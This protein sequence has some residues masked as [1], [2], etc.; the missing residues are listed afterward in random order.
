MLSRQVEILIGN[1]HRQHCLIYTITICHLDTWVEFLWQSWRGK[2][3][4]LQQCCRIVAGC[5]RVLPS[6]AECCRVLPGV[7]AV[8]PHCCRVLPH[9][10]RVLPRCCQQ[11]PCQRENSR[12][13][14]VSYYTGSGDKLGNGTLCGAVEGFTGV[15]MALG[16]ARRGESLD[17]RA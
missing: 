15:D 7:A 5:C 16:H 3:G 12:A 13:R 17:R 2:N 10:C 11:L 9:C 4:S 8:L 1:Y 6:V 14:A